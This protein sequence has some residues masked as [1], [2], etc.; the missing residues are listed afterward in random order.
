MVEDK[1]DGTKR[2]LQDDNLNFINWLVLRLRGTDNTVILYEVLRFDLPVRPIIVCDLGC[3]RHCEHLANSS[4]C[5]CSR[6]A[7]RAHHPDA[8]RRRGSSALSSTRTA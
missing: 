7:L 2:L 4:F 1:K 5:G 3:F 8:A 6:Q